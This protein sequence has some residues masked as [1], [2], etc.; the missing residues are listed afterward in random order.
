MNAPEFPRIPPEEAAAATPTPIRDVGEDDEDEEEE[1]GAG[2]GNRTSGMLRAVR[3]GKRDP[4]WQTSRPSI[5]DI[6]PAAL[7]RPDPKDIGSSPNNRS[8]T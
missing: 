5:N 1:D 2:R 7:L 8:K 3:V 6:H 4:G